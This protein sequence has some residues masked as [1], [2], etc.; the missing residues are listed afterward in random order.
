MQWR[1]K[2]KF[3]KKR[4]GIYT[5]SEAPRA[6]HTSTTDWA[7]SMHWQGPKA[8]CTAS[9]S[10]AVHRQ[11][12]LSHAWHLVAIEDSPQLQTWAEAWAAMVLQ[13]IRASTS[14]VRV[15]GMEIDGRR[16]SYLQTRVKAFKLSFMT[17]NKHCCQLRTDDTSIWTS[18]VMSHSRD[19]EH[20]MKRKSKINIWNSNSLINRIFLTTTGGV[21]GSLIDANHNS[22]SHKQ[23]AL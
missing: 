19:D 3:K 23:Q 14:P 20:K 6:S 15:C 2:I 16:G 13:C 9:L 11:L 17:S 8:S 18:S 4:S 10:S 12:E 1:N 7:R 22:S 5:G 21:K